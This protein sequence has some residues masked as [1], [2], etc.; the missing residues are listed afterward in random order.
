ML[1]LMFKTIITTSIIHK[2]KVDHSK[3]IIKLSICGR[4]HLNAD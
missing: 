1:W 2:L 3:K 4:F